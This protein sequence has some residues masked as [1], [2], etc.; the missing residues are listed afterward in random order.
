MRK[1]SN[2]ALPLQ[3]GED[4]NAELDEE[5][6]EGKLAWAGGRAEAATYEEG[7]AEDARAAAAARTAAERQAGEPQV[8]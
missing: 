2:C 5:N 3:E 1:L 8:L 6:R 4:E 7:D